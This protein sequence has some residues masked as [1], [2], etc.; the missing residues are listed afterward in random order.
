MLQITQSYN[1][2]ANTFGPFNPNVGFYRPTTPP[3]AGTTMPTT[4]TVFEDG[5]K[6]PQTWKTSLAIDVKLP[7]GIIGTLEAIY[8]RDYNVIYSRNINFTTPARLNVAGYPDN[9]MI[10]ENAVPAKYINKLIGAGPGILVP[11]AAGTT[12]LQVI[13]TGN[14]KRGHSGS[15]TVKLD[16]TFKKGFAA[17]VAYTKFIAN[18]L[19]DGVGDQP[20]NTWSLIPTVD[21]ANNPNLSHSGF[22]VPDRVVGTLSYRKEYFKH[23]ATTISFVYQGSIDGRF[24]YVYGGD[25]NRDAVTGNDLIYIPKDARNPAEIQFVASLPINGIVYTP[26][27]QAQLFEDYINQDKYLRKHRGQYAERNGAQLPWRNQVGLKL[28][29]EVFNKFGKNKTHNQFSL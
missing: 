24:S 8:N 4:V 13:L 2:Q 25:F 23:L 21:G 15:F 22:V 10:Y 6:M 7:G 14:E 27:Q 29:K 9:R 19:Y 28:L 20:F 1:G 11:S 12:A 17:T 26:A 5:F 18:A 3:A 16:K